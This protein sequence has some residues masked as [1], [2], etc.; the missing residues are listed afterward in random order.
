MLIVTELHYHRNG[1]FGAG[2]HAGRAEWRAGGQVFKVMFTAF[3]ADEH[4]AILGDNDVMTSYRYEDFAK[5]LR[6][7]VNSRA[8]Q[9]IAFPHMIG[10]KPA[11]PPQPE[12]KR[13]EVG[14]TY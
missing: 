3:E 7:F 1:S 6:K 11:E 8:G 12:L 9:V 10:E 4:I 2:Y 13:F 14:K 5:E